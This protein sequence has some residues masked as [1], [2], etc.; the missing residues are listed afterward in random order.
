[1]TDKATRQQILEFLRD[2]YKRDYE[3]IATGDEIASALNL[4]VEEVRG[5][6]KYLAAKNLIDS[7]EVDLGGE[8][9]CQ[10]NAN[11]L[12]ELERFEEVDDNSETKLSKIGEKIKEAGL[13]K[14]RRKEVAEQ[15]F[16]GAVIELL[17]FQRSEL[18]RREENN[19]EIAEI[20]VRLE[21]LEKIFSNPKDQLIAN[22]YQPAY[23]IMKEIYDNRESL[24]YPPQNPWK[25]VTP[26]WRYKTEL[27]MQKLFEGY[28]KELKKYNEIWVDFGN[29]FMEKKD[30]IGEILRPIF[31]K[32][33]LL[34]QSGDVNFGGIKNPPREWLHNCQ[35][36]IFNDN[37]H[38]EDEFY[39]ILKKD[40]IK[41]YGDKYSLFLDEWKNKYPNIFTD[42]L[43]VIPE[44][45]KE[46]GAKYSY[47][48]F[49]KQ[50]TILKESI[51]K[52]TLALEEKLK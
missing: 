16:Y 32:H 24:N 25:S 18:K 31:E 30:K 2:V 46:L 41:N 22:V 29:K 48:E 38:N 4:P 23:D 12:D 1:M 6:L 52:L 17:D 45:V 8:L 40:A 35:N 21:Q 7:S 14:E 44:L 19:K 5:N 49:D 26:S 13:E 36:V 10:I 11:G 42:L 3:E 39:Q 43:K 33:G 37:I 27:G 20:K 47:A 15:K 9:G 51:E 34:D 28:G 50:R